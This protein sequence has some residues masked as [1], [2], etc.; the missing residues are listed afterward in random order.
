M[1]EG[2]AVTTEVYLSAREVARHLGVKTATLA[3][4]R[5]LKK[6]PP[7]WIKLSETHVAYPA[8]ELEAWKVRRAS[9]YPSPGGFGVQQKAP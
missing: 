8:G 7:G 2:A 1:A 5:Y 9:A 6:G 4:W 3:K